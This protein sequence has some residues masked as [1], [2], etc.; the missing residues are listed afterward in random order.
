MTHRPD[1]D[2]DI[3]LAPDRLDLAA[4]RLECAAHQYR[5]SVQLAAT[6]L[7]AAVRT[8]EAADRLQAA[9]TVPVAVAVEGTHRDHRAVAEA[10]RT[11]HTAA[12]PAVGSGRATPYAP[13][14]TPEFEQRRE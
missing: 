2:M 14:R 4:A 9:G 7:A 10:D 11:P 12:R 3:P 8:L 13:G 6:A 5:A 1:L